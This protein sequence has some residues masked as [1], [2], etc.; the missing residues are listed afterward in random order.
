[1]VKFGSRY[2]KKKRVRRQRFRCQ[3]HGHV[4]ELQKRS[5]EVSKEDRVVLRESLE[6]GSVRILA[7]R[8]AHSKTTIMSVIHRVAALLATSTDVASY[9]RPVWGGILVLDGKYVRTK[10]LRAKRFDGAKRE[11]NLMCWLCGIDA[12]TGDLPHYAIADEETMIDLVLYF[13]HL[14]EIGYDLRVLVCDG[15][16]DFIRAGRKV[17]GDSF[18]VQL[19]TR[20]FLE[21]LRREVIQAGMSED[22]HSW[23]LIRLVQRII[24]AEDLEE[25]GRWLEVLKGK[26]RRLPIHRFI[27]DEFK[28]YADVL[29][30]HLQRPDLC[31]PHTSNEIESL[32]R[33]LNLRL[34]SLGQFMHWKHAENYLNAWAL[35]RRFTPFTDCKGSHKHRNKKTPL[36]CAQCRLE[37]VDMFKIPRGNQ[38]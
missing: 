26:R 36:E 10:H 20:H 4:F 8:F 7:R 22:K 37:G 23:Q 6:R 34:K 27:I 35:L 25:A 12:W 15:N 13:R 18:L 21:R 5:T 3:T 11:R 32:F 14:K 16:P 17:Y 1:M 2:A 29:T 38:P 33:Q 30:T 9:L 24:E 28:Q 31:I 19:C